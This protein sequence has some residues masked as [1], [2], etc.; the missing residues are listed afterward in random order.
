[1]PARA[2]VYLKAGITSVPTGHSGEP[3]VIWGNPKGIWHGW[4]RSWE[5][6]ESR[7]LLVASRPQLPRASSPCAAFTCL[8]EE[9]MKEFLTAA[10]VSY[11]R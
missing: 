4:T 10:G 11:C 9:P 1:M 6:A 7:M 5:W 8:L 2:I 3:S